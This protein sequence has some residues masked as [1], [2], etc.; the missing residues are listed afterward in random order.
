MPL[1]MAPFI[2]D[3]WGKAMPHSNS[4]MPW[5]PVAYHCLDV[6]AAGAALLEVRPELLATLAKAVALP[7]PTVRAWV[8]FA[9]SLHD[10]G[11]FTDCF[12]C[13]VPEHWHHKANWQ[14]KMPNEDRGHGGHGLAIWEGEDRL[15]L[16]GSGTRSF[17]GYECFTIWLR[18]VHGHHGKPV[19]RQS[20]DSLFPA[21]ASE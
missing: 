13:K 20:L 3:Y 21:R 5:H 2:S 7:E 16:F 19:E 1:T 8:L 12:Q 4:K 10:V 18:A 9:L 11:K 14:G 6:A 17:D 15:A